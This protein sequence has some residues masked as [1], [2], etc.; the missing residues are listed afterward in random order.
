MSDSVIITMDKS[1]EM[2]LR[3]DETREYRLLFKATALQQIGLK[4]EMNRLW[5][6]FL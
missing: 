2:D 1:Y 5:C 4:M 6:A 3:F